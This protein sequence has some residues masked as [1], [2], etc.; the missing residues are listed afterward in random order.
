M[1]QLIGKG[2]V[3]RGMLGV[4]I[5][6]VTSDLAQ[7]LG[8]KES[9]GV[10][11]NSVT[12]GGPADKAGL[13]SGDVIVKLNG[14]DVSDPNVLRNEIAGTSPGD[15]VALTINRNGNQ[16]DVRVRLGELTPEN[17]RSQEDQG[18]GQGSAKLGISV[19]PLTPDLANQLH[20]RRGT[21]GVAV[22]DVD[23]NGPAAQAGIQQGDVI[24]EVN[25]QPVRSPE[26]LRNTLQRSGSRTPV[27]LINRNG[28]TAY[29]PVPLE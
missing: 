11:I 10:L 21:Q 15:E 27:L 29:V 20:L 8:L 25:R 23:P 26:D 17:A 4:G 7:G 22:M 14:K 12:P 1:S 5:Q 9:R 18:G 13:K 28:Q 6:P 3:Q 19:A 24:Q 16:Q 2:K